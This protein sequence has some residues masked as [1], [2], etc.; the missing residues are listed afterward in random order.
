MFKLLLTYI[1]TSLFC[2]FLWFL[3]EIL[4]YYLKTPK[5]K[6]DKV[7][8]KET[9]LFKKLFL[10]L[11]RMIGKTLAEEDPNEFGYYGIIFFC[12]PQGSGKTFAMSHYIN[13]IIARYPECKLY[14][15][16]N[17]LVQDGEIT[18][19]KMLFKLNNGKYG[20]IFAFDEIQ[21]D[22]SSRDF[23]HTP[24]DLLQE[25]CFN[26]KSHRIILGTAQ[27]VASIDKALRR[28][29]GEYRRCFCFMKC[30]IIV[31]R[32]KVIFDVDGEIQDK[33]LLGFYPIVQD[34]V[35][36]YMYD[37]LDKVKNLK[38]REVVENDT[39]VIKV[40]TDLPKRRNRFGSGI[41]I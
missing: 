16:Y 20:Q 14:T 33:K 32:F 11:P 13:Q 22:F 10:Y 39:T 38:E 29:C 1:L 19:Y 25:I 9:N 18:D 36:R 37:T 6:S 15:N 23:I 21:N 28:Q 8:F 2:L 12:G 7:L 34:P 17:V 40:Q 30:F 41:R 27:S 31:V 4:Y 24:L 5:I 26:R 35:T 3:L